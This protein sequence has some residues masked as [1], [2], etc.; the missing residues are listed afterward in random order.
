MPRTSGREFRAGSLLLLGLLACAMFIIVMGERP[1]FLHPTYTLTVEFPNA[2]GLSEGS[3]VYL[4]GTSVG[5]V[6]AKPVPDPGTGLIAVK[7]KIDRKTAL[8][9]DATWKVVAPGFIG[10]NFITVHPRAY[11]LD[12]EKAPYLENG[13][14]IQGVAS[15]TWES[16][17]KQARPLIRR[18]THAAGQL[19]DILTRLNSEVLTDETTDDVKQIKSG[20]LKISADSRALVTNGRDLA[21]QVKSERSAIGVLLYDKDVKSD[22]AAFVANYQKSGAIFYHDDSGAGTQGNAARPTWR[23]R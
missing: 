11:A 23:S 20:L 10:D 2:T 5:K 6:A 16:L 22:L 3:G 7:V 12:E 4:L 21:A 15:T 14:V 18:V 17:Q 9:R 19:D 13:D 8:R 1:E